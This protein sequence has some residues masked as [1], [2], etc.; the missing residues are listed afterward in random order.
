MKALIQRV[1]SASVSVDGELVS[2][3]GRGLCVLVGLHRDDGDD[4]LEHVVRK[5][6]AARAFENEDGTRRWCR[7]V[8]DADLEV[9][10]VSQFTLYHTMKGNKPDFRQ[11][12][13]GDASRELYGRFVDTMR[14]LYKAEKVKDGVFGALMQVSQV[15]DGPVTLEIE[16]LPTRKSKEEGDPS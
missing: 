4:Q 9:L 5:V 16:S 8:R 7:S 11:A 15:N 1:G 14:R 13:G 2:S 3:I 10:C 6:L 12:M